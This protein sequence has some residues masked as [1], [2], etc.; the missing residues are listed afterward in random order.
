MRR[1]CCYSFSPFLTNSGTMN[2][3]VLLPI[4]GVTNFC[5]KGKLSFGRSLESCF[6]L[7]CF[8]FFICPYSNQKSAKYR[9]RKTEQKQ[10]CK[11]VQIFHETNKTKQNKTKNPDVYIMRGSHFLRKSMYVIKSMW[12]FC[13]CCCCCCCFCFCSCF[14]FFVNVSVEVQN[15]EPLSFYHFF[16]KDRACL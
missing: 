11:N 8:F 2:L 3:T 6:V 7:F 14:F 13:C 10:I 4:I 12:V 5:L 9:K 16:P 15:F 1:S